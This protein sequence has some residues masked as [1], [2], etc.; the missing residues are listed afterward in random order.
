MQEQ[1]RDERYD[2]IGRVDAPNLCPLSGVLQ[3]I[4]MTGCRIK[5]P[6]QCTVDMES[7]VELT[8]TPA[9][10]KAGQPI[11]LIG[12]PQWVKDETD[13]C[14]IGL[15]LLH[16]P[17]SRLLGEYIQRLALAAAEYDEEEEMLNICSSL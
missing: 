3:D 12:Q 8:I 10:K 9:H 16:S 2:D 15:K 4:S 14:E 11:V 1:R 17:G 6:V 13:S 7:E 5:F